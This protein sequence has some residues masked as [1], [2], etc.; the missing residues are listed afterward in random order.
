MVRDRFWRERSGGCDSETSISLVFFRSGHRCQL[1]SYGVQG[2]RTISPQS[3]GS[4]TDCTLTQG[5]CAV[6]LRSQCVEQPASRFIQDYSAQANPYGQAALL[7]AGAAVEG[8]GQRNS[9]IGGL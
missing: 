2:L 1:Y 9:G 7:S 6:V 3:G 4:T 5:R 8:P